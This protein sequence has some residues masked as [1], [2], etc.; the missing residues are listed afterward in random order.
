MS[1]LRDIAEEINWTVTQ[2]KIR[3]RIRKM[4]NKIFKPKVRLIEDPGG[5]KREN[6]EKAT[7]NEIK[8]YKFSKTYEK[9][10]L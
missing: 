1:E 5:S 3:Y 4:K 9:L 6:G 2:R 8:N 7:L 10:V